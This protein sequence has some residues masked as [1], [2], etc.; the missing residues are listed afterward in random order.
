MAQPVRVLA[1]KPKLT[2]WLLVLERELTPVVH[3]QERN[4]PLINK[5]K[6]LYVQRLA[7]TLIG[8]TLT[9]FYQ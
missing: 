1:T 4:K 5:K 2:Y 7:E 8:V 3:A 6:F 9:L